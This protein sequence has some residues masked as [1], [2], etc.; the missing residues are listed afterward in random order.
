M[1]AACDNS[2]RRRSKSSATQK[3]D[4][5]LAWLQVDSGGQVLQHPVSHVGGDVDTDIAPASK[6]AGFLELADKPGRAI[7]LE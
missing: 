5:Q 3:L 1:I 4:P 7:A 6:A 2:W